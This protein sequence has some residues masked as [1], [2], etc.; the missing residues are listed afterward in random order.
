MWG[1]L[2]CRG[3]SGGGSGGVS[4]L[5]AQSHSPCA[6]GGGGS[7]GGGFGGPA[8]IFWG[9]TVFGVQVGD[10][11]AATRLSRA[12][13]ERGLYVQ[14]INPPTVPRGGELLR[15]APTPHHTPA[16][17]EHLAGEGGTRGAGGTWGC[18]EWRELGDTGGTGG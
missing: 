8:G 17:M 12:L 10:A 18:W 1:N 11:L 7:S 16:M 5:P 3:G 14:A 4:V 6:R 13:L 9:V 15:I 2:G